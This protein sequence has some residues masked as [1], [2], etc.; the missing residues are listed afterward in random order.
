MQTKDYSELYLDAQCAIKNCH[1]FCLKSDWES[2]SKAAEAASEYAKQ[3][4]D[5]IKN[6]DHIYNRRS[7]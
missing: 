6:Y 4:Q 1:L 5:T 7:A 2:A 3:L